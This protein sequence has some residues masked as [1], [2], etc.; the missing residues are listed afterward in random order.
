MYMNEIGR[1]PLLEHEEEVDL[2]KRIAAGKAAKEVMAEAVWVPDNLKGVVIADS[3]RAREKMMVSNLR[4]VV[5]MSFDFTRRYDGDILGAIQ[6]GNLGLHHAVEKFD[7]TKG[8]KFSTYAHSWIYQ[9]LQRGQRH[10]RLTVS[11]PNDA[12]QELTRFKK[13]EEELTM[14]YGHRPE[15]E[16]IAEEARVDLE[17]I[18][19]MR[20]AQWPERLDGP[21]RVYQLNDS[22]TT[23]DSVADIETVD[24]EEQ[25]I[26]HETLRHMQGQIEGAFESLSED[27]KLV[28]RSRYG[29]D[30]LEPLTIKELAHNLGTTRYYVKKAQAQAEKKIREHFAGSR[31]TKGGQE[32]Y[33]KA[34]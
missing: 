10:N 7:H 16:E 20:A 17:K 27:E 19:D 21:R 22:R 1:Y 18:K 24:V 3:E 29:F 30:G 13:T 26:E 31:D 25:V 14:W 6:E 23:A 4:L 8:Y 34:S 9:A 33:P 12:T 32:R 11:I 2:A 15:D 5:N 28:L